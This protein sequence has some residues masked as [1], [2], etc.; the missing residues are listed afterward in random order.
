M[1]QISIFHKKHNLIGS[2]VVLF[3]PQK[4]RLFENSYFRYI[5]GQKDTLTAAKHVLCILNT[6]YGSKKTGENVMKSISII[7]K[8]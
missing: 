8:G 3:K 1:G 5:D 6:L 2:L 4:N 7:A